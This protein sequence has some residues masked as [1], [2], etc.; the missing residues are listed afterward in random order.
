[1]GR[2]QFLTIQLPNGFRDLNVEDEPQED[3]LQQ[4]IAENPRFTV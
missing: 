3:F 2:L 4:L 1:M